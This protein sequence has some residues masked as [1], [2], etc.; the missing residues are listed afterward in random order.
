MHA[1]WPLPALHGF[2][3]SDGT[4]MG[5]WLSARF[6]CYLPLLVVVLT[7]SSAAAAP[8]S[9]TTQ[10]GSGSIVLDHQVWLA[11]NEHVSALSP[12]N[13]VD[14]SFRSGACEAPDPMTLACRDL[15]MSALNL[16]DTGERAT[17]RA[18]DRQ[19]QRGTIRLQA[20]EL[21]TTQT[22]RSARDVTLRFDNN[23]L[24]AALDVWRARELTWDASSGLHAKDVLIRH[25]A[26]QS[27]DT[28]VIRIDR[29]HAT[30]DTI[31]LG[32]IEWRRQHN[33]DGD[34]SSPVGRAKLAVWRAAD[35]EAGRPSTDGEW[36]VTGRRAVINQH[37]F[38]PVGLGTSKP[39]SGIGVLPP[40][41]SANRSGG[42]ARSLVAI[43]PGNL[44][45]G[46]VFHAFGPDA[47]VGAG[48]AVGIAAPHS[49]D[50]PLSDRTSTDFE[51]S[52]NPLTVEIVAPPAGA[53]PGVVASGEW[54]TDRQQ[55]VSTSGQLEAYNNER[56]W[57][58]YHHGADGAFRDWR[59]STAGLS[60]TGPRHE[61]AFA[62]GATQPSPSPGPRHWNLQF[63]G[64]GQL[65]VDDPL[66]ADAT[67]AYAGTHSPN[68]GF[69]GDRHTFVA[70]TRLNWHNDRS[71]PTDI[72]LDA[73]FLSGVALAP[74]QVTA[75]VP[76]GTR[77]V[78]R[79]MAVIGANAEVSVTGRIGDVIHRVR[80]DLSAQLPAA[81]VESTAGDGGE[82]ADGTES[83]YGPP[84]AGVAELPGSRTGEG[85]ATAMIDQSLTLP[86]ATLRFPVGAIGAFDRNR[87]LFSVA[88]FGLVTA[89]TER[90]RLSAAVVQPPNGPH[91]A[92]GEGRYHFSNGFIGYAYTVGGRA[93]PWL[94]DL[95]YA[96]RRPARRLTASRMLTVRSPRPPGGRTTAIHRLDAGI[97]IQG[98]RA[99]MHVT[100]TSDEAPTPGLSL[101]IARRLSSLGWSVGFTGMAGGPAQRFGGILGLMSSR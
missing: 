52:W 71:S 69:H 96:G 15:F 58:P 76:A 41:F 63:V 50:W 68:E 30:S 62:A 77:T 79:S 78:S 45:V 13:I 36:E 24:L 27:E 12:S 21:R 99:G 61:V 72:A 28:V 37:L 8:P 1:D 22:T 18:K 100:A 90:W 66:N 44:L 11:V 47:G 94:F 91:T 73:Q 80:A 17:R 55:G 7:V 42:D 32:N 67:I 14:A 2:V 39:G 53:S 60:H 35:S 57:T 81:V 92:G 74:E 98:W 75:V 5:N 26:P 46:P 86:T 82:F 48:A 43:G 89:D 3:R 4:A 54:E 10:S 51:R 65:P 25:S 59:S 64:S 16:P 31:I 93:V 97:E 33:G 88:P 38:L 56:L 83:P 49:D 6:A 85:A 95:T 70:D 19:V 84:A 34:L 101:R 20:A 87:S 40:T 29:V 9:N 23:K